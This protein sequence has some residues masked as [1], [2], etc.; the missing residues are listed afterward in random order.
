MTVSTDIDA[1]V[2]RVSPGLIELRRKLHQHPEL[3]FEE[4]Q[5]AQAVADYLRE[6]GVEP[7]TGIG[8][9][10]VVGVIE[11]AAKGPTIGVRA[12]MDALPIQE[13]SG[14]A[15]A[16]QNAGRMHACGHDV[17]TVIALGVGQVLHAMRGQ[18]RGKVKLIFQ[19]A[20]ETL[21]GAPAMIA[22]GVLDDP[23]MDAVIGYHNWPPLET[24]CVGYYQSVIMASSDAFDIVLKGRGAHAA[25][26]HT[27]IDAIIGAAHLVTQLQ[28]I[29]SREIA[30]VIP[31]VITIGQIEGG[32]A[33][34]VIA[35]RVTL[36]GT[37]RTLDAAAAKHVESA[38]R[39]ILD[40][41][42]LSHRLEYELAWN[43]QVPVLRNDPKVL[44]RVLGSAR[45]VLGTDQVRDMGPP[46]MGSE[47][48]AWFA[49]RVP[50]AHL[51]I[52]SKIDGLDTAIHR[53]NYDCNDL[54][55]PIGVRVMTRAVLE[56]AGK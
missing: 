4:H 44:A 6:M 21:A 17:H 52:G 26:P 5:T 43:K 42:A 9:T 3:A 38:L 39:R 33:R 22:D 29:V 31:A 40:G 8:K 23:A 50:A 25:H 27:G 15:F 54:A 2:A 47:D 34:N 32:T 49:E 48:F 36:K 30:P 28:T 56:L 20:E 14:V 19:P 24:G 7:R 35:N 37:A 11:G 41:L 46:S 1:I 55:I 16:S 53:A 18:L 13:Q 10:G 45:G 51:R 12:D